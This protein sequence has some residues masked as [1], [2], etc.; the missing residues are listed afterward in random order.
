[1]CAVSQV[2]VS[3]YE[4]ASS[5]L[6]EFDMDNSIFGLPREFVVA[7]AGRGSDQMTVHHRVY[8]LL[9]YLSGAFSLLC[10]SLHDSAGRD[11][12]HHLVRVRCQVQPSERR[13]P[14][15]AAA[16]RRLRRRDPAHLNGLQEVSA[17]PRVS[18]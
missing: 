15:F 7:S 14:P 9:K 10:S 5:V 11:R 3:S 2:V 12:M 4:A 1:M 6:I 13:L 18:G 8:L 17:R 16:S